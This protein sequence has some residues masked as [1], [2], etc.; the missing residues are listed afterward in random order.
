MTFENHTE[1]VSSFYDTIDFCS[2]SLGEGSPLKHYI[3]FH[4]HFYKIFQG[5]TKFLPTPL[6]RKGGRN[7]TPVFNS[8]WLPSDRISS[9]IAD[10]KALLLVQQTGFIGPGHL[11]AHVLNGSNESLNE[12]RFINS[13]HRQFAS[14]AVFSRL[15]LNKKPL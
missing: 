6:L 2:V 8:E 3:Y 9:L 1:K 11:C 10:K 13:P 14:R 4:L 12:S 15:Q 7:P 5:Q